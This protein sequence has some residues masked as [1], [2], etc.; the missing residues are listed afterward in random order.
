M[1]D[2]MKVM[3]GKIV[4]NTIWDNIENV[5]LSKIRESLNNNFSTQEEFDSIF[6]YATRNFI[7]SNLIEGQWMMN[8]KSHD[9]LKASEFLKRLSNFRFQY[10]EY[11]QRNILI[12][13][14]IVF[15]IG[16]TA[17]VLFMNFFDMA[18]YKDILWGVFAMIVSS[19]VLLPI[20]NKRQERFKECV[21]AKYRQQ[22]ESLRIA[23][24]ESIS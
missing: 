7:N 22:L 18:V 3:D 13:Y 17:S 6:N 24:E 16:V 14:M 2:K 10:I 1:F 20:F 8:L 23:L 19:G 5:V 15:I 9:E 12:G 11:S 4:F 21:I